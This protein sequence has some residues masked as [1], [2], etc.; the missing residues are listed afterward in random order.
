MLTCRC[1]RPVLRLLN[2]RYFVKYIS[3]SWFDC[4]Y[5]SVEVKSS[6]NCV[7]SPNCVSSSLC[8]VHLLSVDARRRINSCS[9][10][11]TTDWRGWVQL[12][13]VSHPEPMTPL[14]VRTRTA[15]FSVQQQFRRFLNWAKT[16]IMKMMMPT[17]VSMSS[18]LPLKRKG[19]RRRF[20]N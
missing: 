14:A 18:S 12:S 11:L 15:S 19:R 3:N 2:Y 5:L 16:M 4:Y 10:R 17:V 1:E 8:I 9:I 13:V 7:P 6:S 20:F